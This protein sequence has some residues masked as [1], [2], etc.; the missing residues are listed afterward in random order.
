MPL[1]AQSK[2]VLE[3]MA[4]AGL[5]P[6]ETTTPG[7]ARDLRAAMRSSFSALA[8]S[9]A[10]PAR[11]EDRTVAGIPVRVYWPNSVKPL[12]I[13]VYFHG[14]G[15][16]LGDIEGYD[17]ACRALAMA[18]G[19]IVVSVEYRLAPEHPY[20]AAL[21][22]CY[23]AT[24]YI[25]EHA[26][27]FDADAGRLAVGGDSAGGNLAAAVTLLA[28]ESGGPE[29][30][31]QLLIYPVTDYSADGGSF[32]EFGEGYFLT[33]AGMRWF[34]QQ[35]VGKAENGQKYWVSPIKA[36]DFAGLPAAFVMTAEC[37]V[38]RDQGE[39]YARCLEQAGVRVHLKRYEGAIHG[40]F[41]M[42]GM[43]DTGKEAMSDAG[44]ALWN[45]LGARAA[46]AGEVY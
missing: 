44:A 38:L 27:E 45:T 9:V 29:I 20:P 22:D 35:Y 31:F 16:V 30:H 39:A 23:T 3:M 13:L 6:I 21:E 7:Q 19:C 11:I 18:S 1:D 34:W 43:L 33:S 25:A 42:A 26:H 41:N 24:K 32:Q 28:R 36:P 17:P 46:T 37:D 8:G 10:E 2:A 40:F 15:W 4:A 14:G 5:P 12:P